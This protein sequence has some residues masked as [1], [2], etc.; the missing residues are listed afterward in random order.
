[1]MWTLRVLF[2]CV[3]MLVSIHA[4][5]PCAIDGEATSGRGEAERDDSPSTMF[6]QSDHLLAFV[7]AIVISVVV[8][9]LHCHRSSPRDDQIP[10][11]HT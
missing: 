10:P 3:F 2:L 1:M 7:N 8:V 6:L 4:F 9:F 5:E 11:T